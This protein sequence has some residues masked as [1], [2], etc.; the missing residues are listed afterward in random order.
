MDLS[1]RR[2]I[3]IG[4]LVFVALIVV[5]VIMTGSNAPA[6]NASVAKIVS[7]YHQHKTN[8]LV[9]AYL[10]EL[11]VFVG[12]FFFWYLRGLLVADGAD[13]TLATLSF[14]GAVIFGVSGG[15][16]GGILW[17]LSDAANNVGAAT[18]QTLNILQNDLNTTLT[19]A[20]QAVFLAATGYVVVK[21]S[22]M[23]RWLGWLAIVFAVVALL[24][25]VGPIPT[26]LW[27]LIASIVI[28]AKSG[29]GQTQLA[30]T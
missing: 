20:G 27:V 22:A 6:S 23:T 8:A 24:G 19:G 26:G 17:A 3:G 28:L 11:A 2:W 15:I 30:T 7:F 10:L 12:L 25:V 14:A 18:M 29:A 1:L 9:S 5:S 13:R 16:A 4:G 21:S